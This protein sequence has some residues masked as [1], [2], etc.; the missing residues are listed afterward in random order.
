MSA[1]K[2]GHELLLPARK[3]SDARSMRVG[4]LLVGLALLNG[5]DL[6]YSVFAQQIHQLYEVNPLIA[7][8]LRHGEGGLGLVIAMKVVLVAM[9]LA[10]LW[11]LRHNWLTLPAC[12]VLMIAYGSLGVVWMAWARTISSTMELQ[13]SSTVQ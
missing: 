4:L 10:V 6:V 8:L 3:R 11:R 1:A 7:P 9:G 5:V 2:H 12:W 13:L